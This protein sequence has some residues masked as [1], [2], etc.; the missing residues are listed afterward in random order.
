MIIRNCNL[1]KVSD[2]NN[3]PSLS[4]RYF[5][6]SN[7]NCLIDYENRESERS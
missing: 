1:I 4:L 5:L 3:D 6:R 7:I 2:I